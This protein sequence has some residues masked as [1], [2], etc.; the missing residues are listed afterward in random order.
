MDTNTEHTEQKSK[1][2]RQ[3]LNIVG[4]GVGGVG[5]VGVVGVVGV[6]VNIHICK[7]CQR[8]Y[9]LLKVFQKH[10]LMCQLIHSQRILDDNVGDGSV[11]SVGSG[12]VPDMVTMYRM[13]LELARRNQVLEKKV[14]ELSSFQYQV[15]Q[16]KK[17][18]I[19]EWLE[20]SQTQPMVDFKTRMQQLIHIQRQD[21]ELVFQYG[22]IKAIALF[23]QNK[24]EINNGS[25]DSSPL[26]FAFK[27][28]PN[29]FYLY[30]ECDDNK[31]NWRKMTDDEFILL[32]NKVMK[33]FMREFVV[34]QEENKH[35]MKN[36]EAFVLQYSKNVQLVM[37]G[38][39]SREYIYQQVRR[40]LFSLIAGEIP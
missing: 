26:L 35:R 18:G 38:E 27:I 10:E 4:G 3:K 14:R 9:K 25:T 28:E 40:R 22:L 8:E 11:G 13:I 21:L 31:F 17:L 20:Q 33:E 23:L 6:G 1:R 16:K 36:D 15:K 39:Y 24:C 2:Q 37:G 29:V 12:S 34:W 32:V 5:G 30:G 7:Y 19:L